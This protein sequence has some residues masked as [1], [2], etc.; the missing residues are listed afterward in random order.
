MEKGGIF[1]FVTKRGFA[2]VIHSKISMELKLIE[3]GSAVGLGNTPVLYSKRRL[4][5]R[6]N[7]TQVGLLLTLSAS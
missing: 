3:T 5:N 6:V 4:L 7:F 2:Q 1:Q